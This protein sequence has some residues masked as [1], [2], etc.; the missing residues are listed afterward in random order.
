[1]SWSPRA[2]WERLLEAAGQALVYHWDADGVASAAILVRGGAEPRWLGPPAIGRYS[3]DAVAGR[4]PRWVRSAAVLDYGIPGREYALLARRIGSIAALDHHRTSPPSESGSLVYCNPVAEGSMSEA[5]APACS[6]LAL[7]VS[8]L[9]DPASRLLAALG[10]AGDLSPYIDSGHPHSGL[11]IARE[12]ARG[13]GWSLAGLRRLA[14]MVDS[15]YRLLDYECL[16]DAV[17]AAAEEGLSGLEELECLRRDAE[18]ERGLLEEALARLTLLEKGPSWAVYRLDM[19]AYVTSLVGR[20]LASERPGQIVALIHVMP[21]EGRAILYIR[22]VGGGL[23]QLRE[24]LAAHGLKTAGKESVIVVEAPAGEAA[25]LLG[26]LM[27]ALQG[28]SA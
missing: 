10:V 27:E 6:V 11:E 23:E 12:L 16:V 1:M 19:D 15:A 2:C 25:K 21:R 7:R 5:Q 24:A 3:A 8:G 9:S 4:L 20:R 28:A 14:G 22:R 26:P 13:S 18:R 17:R